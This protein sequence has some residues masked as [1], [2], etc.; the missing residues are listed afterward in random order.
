M[1]PYVR[2]EIN[3]EVRV[4]VGIDPLV[5]IIRTA[6]IVAKYIARGTVLPMERNVRNVAKKT[7]SNL[8]AEVAMINVTQVDQGQRKATKAKGFMK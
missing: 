4:M 2:A 1:M 3:Q 6:N 8:Y 7:T 5:V